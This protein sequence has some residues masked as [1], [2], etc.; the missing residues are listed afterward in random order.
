MGFPQ[1]APNWTNDVA[2][3]GVWLSS[4][5]KRLELVLLTEY[6]DESLVLL[7]RRM[8]WTTKDIVYI[9]RNPTT[10][11]HSAGNSAV[12]GVRGVD[13]VIL[14]R[15]A[16]Q[17]RRWSKADVALY[18]H[19]SRKFWRQISA[20]D[21]TFW[22]EVRQFRTVRQL[23]LDFCANVSYVGSNSVTQTF[24]AFAGEMVT[25]STGDC[26]I[27]SS[28]LMPELK[29][30]YDAIPVSVKPNFLKAVGPPC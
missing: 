20:E 19:F 14:Q 18:E 6:F 29:S 25:L 17:F 9:S 13:N 3:T 11:R 26:R 1:G 23:V 10:W 15:L 7:R 12:V 2:A 27:L 24:T 28:R 30:F 22:S 5:D 4:L 8:C 16:E 21:E